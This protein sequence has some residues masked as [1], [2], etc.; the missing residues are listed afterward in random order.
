[1]HALL[2]RSGVAAVV[3]ASLFAL[4]PAAFAQAVKYKAG[5]KEI[6]D[7]FVI[8]KADRPGA[9]DTRRDLDQMLELSAASPDGWS[10]PIQR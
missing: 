1:M 3:A 4:T 9:V 5:L 6:A 2:I 7:V 10:P 8:N